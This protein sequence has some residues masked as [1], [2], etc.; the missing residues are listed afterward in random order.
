MRAQK[1]A[2]IILANLII[3]AAGLLLWGCA[4][5]TP[6][7]PPTAAPSLTPYSTPTVEATRPE[8]PPSTPTIA[9]PQAPETYNVQE[10]DT[11]GAIALAYDVS[12]EDLILAND[13]ANPNVLYVGQELTIPI[14]GLPTPSLPPT[15]APSPTTGPVQETASPPT[16]TSS[17][18]A[19]VEIVQVSGSGDPA[20]EVAVIHNQGGAVDLE[21]WTLADSEGDS[22]EFPALTLFGDA[23]THLHTTTGIDTPHDLH[24]GRAEP[25]WNGGDLL[26]LRDSD[27][28]VVDTYIV[29]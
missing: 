3:L 22:F 25:A 8:S 18:P 6:E 7:L 2:V 29:R 24:W 20:A 10:G 16:P 1:R 23:E 11:L 26:V 21:G 27:G 13:L 14:G 19:R 4:S 17:S 15:D 28:D 12:I 5:E 9:P